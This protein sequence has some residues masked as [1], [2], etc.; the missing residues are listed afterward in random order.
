VGA[1]QLCMP[2]I[3]PALCIEAGYYLRHGK[4]LT[5]ISLETLGYQ[6]LERLYE[7]LLGSLLVGPLLGLTTAGIIYLM[8]LFLL[9][10]NRVAD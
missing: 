7:W 3:V 6:G 4:F 5:E 8:A 1:S 2:P 9:R 10:S